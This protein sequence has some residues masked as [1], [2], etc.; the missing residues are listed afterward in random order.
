MQQSIKKERSSHASIVAR[1]ATSCITAAHPKGH[2]SDGQCGGMRGDH[3]QDVE[4][5][6]GKNL[7]NQL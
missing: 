7:E 5:V 2:P 1:K 4:Q 6:P 3:R